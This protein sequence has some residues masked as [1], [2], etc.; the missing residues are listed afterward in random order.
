MKALDKIEAQGDVAVSDRDR[1]ILIDKLLDLKN[2]LAQQI[3][4]D[5]TKP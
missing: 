4:D 1:Q 3:I 5:G 2:L